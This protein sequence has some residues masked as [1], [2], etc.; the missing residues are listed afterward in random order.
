MQSLFAAGKAPDAYET[1]RGK[2]SSPKA[3]FSSSKPGR[4]FS[5][6]GTPGRALSPKSPNPA[7]NLPQPE[8]DEAG[9]EKIKASILV[10]E[11]EIEEQ[12]KEREAEAKSIDELVRCLHSPT[13]PRPPGNDHDATTS[14]PHLSPPPV[15]LT[16]RAHL[17]PSPLALTGR[18]HLAGARARHPQQERDQDGQRDGPGRTLIEP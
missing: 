6:K 1:P 8:L 11:G 9:R 17:S 5:P 15:A 10:V 12:R 18:P 2:S 16:S 4:A 14:Y 7:P 13:P 3:D